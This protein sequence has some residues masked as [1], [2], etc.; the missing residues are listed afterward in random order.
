MSY[1]NPWKVAVRTYLRPFLAYFFPTIEDDIDW[2]REP[3]FLDKELLQIL[4]E[5]E[6]GTRFADMLVSIYRKSGDE[7]WVLIHIEIQASSDAAFGQRMWI[8]H[9][10]IF[11]CFRRPLAS[12]AILADTNPDWRPSHYETELWGCRSRLDFLIS[13]L[14]DFESDIEALETSQDPIRLI[15]AAH[16]RALRTRSDSLAR[17]NSK[18]DWCAGSTRWAGRERKS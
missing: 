1:D 5:S 16:L 11:D 12:L 9:Y 14:I 4:P 18:S 2:T 6:T 3:Q 8:Y 17:R 15:V 10:K 7:A 13:K